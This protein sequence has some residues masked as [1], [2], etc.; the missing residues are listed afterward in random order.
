MIMFTQHY[1]GEMLSFKPALM[2]TSTLKEV[3]SFIRVR[4]IGGIPI[5]L[6]VASRVVLS[7]I[8]VPASE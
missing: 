4:C 8:F 6:G 7:L 1:K 2:G 3:I 5:Q